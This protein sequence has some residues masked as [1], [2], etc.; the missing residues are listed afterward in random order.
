MHCQRLHI[1]GQLVQGR[2]Y[3]NRLIPVAELDKSRN[4]VAHFVYA[5]KANVPAYMIK[6]GTTYRLISNHLGSVRLVVNTDT[7]DIAQRL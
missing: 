6:G 2:R 4:V 1:G 3:R 7:G 5:D